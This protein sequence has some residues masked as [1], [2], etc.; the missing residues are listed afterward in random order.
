MGVSL[1]P[2]AGAHQPGDAAVAPQTDA[3]SATKVAS[4]SKVLELDDVR[5]MMLKISA[6]IMSGEEEETS[7]DANLMDQGLDSLSAL[8]FRNSLKERTGLKLPGTLMYDYPTMREVALHIV[9]LSRS[10]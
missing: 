6:E 4:M 2:A 3:A 5:Q 10:S 8:S 1:Y 7:F 9:D